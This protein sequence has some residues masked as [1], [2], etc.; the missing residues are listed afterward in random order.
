MFHKRIANV[1]IIVSLIISSPLFAFNGMSPISYGARSGGMGGAV[2][3]VGGSVMDL[4]TNPAHLAGLDNT[5]IEGGIN[6]AK[7]TLT[8]RDSFYDEDARY[9]YTNKVSS[10]PSIFPLP[11]TG[12]AGP[13]TDDIGWGVA[14][15]AEGGVGGTFNGIKRHFPNRMTMNEMM[16]S[17]L[18]DPSASVPYMGDSTLMTENTYSQFAFARLT[19]GVAMEFGKFKIGVGLDFGAALMEWRWTFSDPS[20]TMEMPGAGYRYKSDPAYSLSGKIGVSYELLEGLTV[21]YT[22]KART[23]MYFDGDT[24]INAGN[25]NYYMALDTSAYMEW[26]ESHNAGIAYAG[27][28]FT[29]SMDLR[30]IK[31][32]N[33]INTMEFNLPYAWVQTP[34]GNQSAVLPFSLKWRDQRVIALGGEYKPGMV[35]FRAGYNYGNSPVTGAGINPLFPAITEHHFTTGL[36]L[37]FGDLDVDFAVEYAAPKTVK[38]SDMSDWDM[39][40]AIEGDASQ[41]A[42]YKM[43]QYNHSVTMSSISLIAGVKYAI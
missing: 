31:W 9:S 24:S 14:F 11:Y 12:I 4:Q 32:S 30:Y 19:P 18:G 41:I 5:I 27:D 43:M 7:P 39:F 28:E 33:V 29:I 36:G 37:D 13:V 23:K 6:L 38:G 25:P 22:Y 15:Y 40:H 16:A 3:A 34:L 21:A 1:F 8:Y 35:A 17:Q 20:G 10:E 2:T 26:P 42:S